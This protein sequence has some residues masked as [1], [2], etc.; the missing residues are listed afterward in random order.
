MSSRL[1]MITTSSSVDR[2]S[3]GKLPSARNDGSASDAKRAMYALPQTTVRNFVFGRIF[4]DE[5]HDQPVALFAGMQ[6]R[7]WRGSV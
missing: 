3:A 6:V 4:F 2:A 5:A 1:V 7:G